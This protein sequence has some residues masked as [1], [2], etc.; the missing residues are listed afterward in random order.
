[1][2]GQYTYQSEDEYSSNPQYIGKYYAVSFKDLSESKCSFSAA[3]KDND[4]K[5]ETL[6][7]AIKKFTIEN[8]YFNVY[9]T[10]SKTTDTLIVK[11]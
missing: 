4:Y 3:L 6:E 8:S 11:P 7:E 10:C 1:M 9:T 2:Y 5:A